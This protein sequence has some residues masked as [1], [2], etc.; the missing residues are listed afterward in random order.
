MTKQILSKEQNIFATVRNRKQCPLCNSPI[1]EI[2]RV[3]GDIELY[4][5]RWK[6]DNI[7]CNYFKVISNDKT[8]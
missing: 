7:K 3:W 8:Q 4:C 2:M 1:L 5:T 6:V